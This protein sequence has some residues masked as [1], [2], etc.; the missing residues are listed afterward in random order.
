MELF[1]FTAQVLGRMYT[2]TASNDGNGIVVQ[3]PGGAEAARTIGKAEHIAHHA[4]ALILRA[5]ERPGVPW[6]LQV[7]VAGVQAVYGEWPRFM[8]RGGPAEVTPI[9]RLREQWHDGDG[10]LRALENAIKIVRTYAGSHAA[11][12]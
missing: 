12:A 3:T 9:V 4:I 6:G 11:A 2:A 5:A 10:P 8:G 7:S 1:S